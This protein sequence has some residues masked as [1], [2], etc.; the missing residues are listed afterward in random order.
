MFFMIAPKASPTT[1]HVVSFGSVDVIF[2]PKVC[3]ASFHETTPPSRLSH[4][5]P[6]FFPEGEAARQKQAVIRLGAVELRPRPLDGK[7]LLYSSRITD[8]L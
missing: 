3:D 2:P 1:T 8:F 6:L 7:R 4:A 5:T